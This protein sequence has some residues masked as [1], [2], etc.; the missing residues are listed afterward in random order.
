MTGGINA[1]L[2]NTLYIECKKNYEAYTVIRDKF[3]GTEERYQAAFQQ[4]IF[5]IAKWKLSNR[6]CFYLWEVLFIMIDWDWYLL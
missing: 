2:Q 1:E 6:L 4:K 5:L 3:S